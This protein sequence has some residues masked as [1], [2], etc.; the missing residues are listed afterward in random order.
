MIG[1]GLGSMVPMAAMALTGPVG[2]G[3]AAATGIAAGAGEATERAR[4][5]GASEEDIDTAGLSG[6]AIGAT[7]MLPIFRFLN[8]GG[9]E[10][11]Q[12]FADKVWRYV[13]SATEEGV[14]EAAAAMAQNMVEQQVYNPDADILNLDVAAEGGV[15]ATVGAIT[16]GLVD[17]AMRGKRRGLTAGEEPTPETEEERNARIQTRIGDKASRLG[18]DREDGQMDMFG[19]SDAMGPEAP[20]RAEEE[21]VDEE[22]T[23]EGLPI[24]DLF[25]ETL[26]Q[27]IDSPFR[28]PFGEFGERNIPADKQL[29]IVEDQT[30]P[31]ELL[32]PE[33]RRYKAAARQKQLEAKSA[34]DEKPKNE[35]EARKEETQAQL[36]EAVDTKKAQLEAI[37]GMQAQDQAQAA[38][39]VQAANMQMQG[40]SEPQMDLFPETR[41]A[42]PA[43]QPKAETPTRE[44][45]KPDPRQGDLLTGR[46]GQLPNVPATQFD[47]VEPQELL[48]PR[49][50]AAK[51][52]AQRKQQEAGPAARMAE[53]R[54][55]QQQQEAQQRSA[56]QA[57]AYRGQQ[58]TEQ[59]RA[60]Q[61]AQ[62]TGTPQPDMFGGVRGQVTPEPAAQ[63]ATTPR[64]ITKEMLD[65]ARILPAAPIR[66]RVTG[67][68]IN[69]PAVQ[70]DLRN[71]A[72]NKS[73][74]ATAKAGVNKLLQDAQQQGDLF[75]QPKRQPKPEVVQ[76]PVQEVKD[77]TAE[78]KPT[79]VRASS[80]DRGRSDEQRGRTPSA[81]P[82]GKPRAPERKRLAE[83]KPVPSKPARRAVRVDDTLEQKPAP[84]RITKPK[85]KKEEKPKAKYG[86]VASGVTNWKD[87]EPTK[88]RYVFRQAES[89]VPYDPRFDVK[90]KPK[91][92]KV[93]AEERVERADVSGTY[94]EQ[95]SQLRVLLAPKG[96]LD[97]NP[98][99]ENHEVTDNLPESD[100]AAIISVIKNT[101]DPGAK[102]TNEAWAARNYFV[103]S[104]HDRF[105][106]NL[107]LLGYDLANGTAKTKSVYNWVSKNLSPEA[108][109][110]VDKWT[111]RFDAE[112]K[113]AAH[114]VNRLDTVI[115][116]N[117]KAA[118]AAEQQLRK[119]TMGDM[120]EFR[121]SMQ[122]LRNIDAP[123]TTGLN[124]IE[125]IFGPLFRKELAK[126][127]PSAATLQTIHPD[128]SEALM[129]G[130][131]QRAL[132]LVGE[133]NPN[134][135]VQALA[136]KLA[137]MVGTTKV[138]MVDN[139]S[140]YLPEV[141]GDDILGY[142]YPRTNTIVIRSDA[143]STHT[144]L[145]EMMHAATKF[146]LVKQGHPV[147]RQLD[148]IFKEA[149]TAAQKLYGKENIEKDIYGL[150]DLDEFVAESM[151]DPEMQKFLSRIKSDGGKVNLWDRF[152]NA[153][154]NLVRNMLGYPSKPPF[155][156][157][158]ADVDHLVNTILAPAPRYINAN[159]NAYKS[160]DEIANDIGGMVAKE[161]NKTAG[162]RLKAVWEAVAGSARAIP[163][164]LLPTNALVDLVKDKIPAALQLDK[165]IHAQS[166]ELAKYASIN[167]ATIKKV[168]TWNNKHGTEHGKLLKAV[169]AESTVAEVDP[170]LTRKEAEAKYVLQGTTIPDQEK[171][172]VWSKLQE[173]WSRLKSVGGAEIYQTMRNSYKMYFDKI[174]ND[175]NVQLGETVTDPAML[176]QIREVVAKT[177]IIDPYFPLARTGRFWVKYTATDNNGQPDTY[178]EA[179]ESE[180]ERQAAI[181]ELKGLGAKDFETYVVDSNKDFKKA[182]P[183]SFMADLNK[184]LA[185]NKASKELKEAVTNLFLD[186][187]PAHSFM[188]SFK[189]RERVS[190]FDSDAI[191]VFEKRIH[192]LSHQAVA[193]KY[194]AQLQALQN[195]LEQSKREEFKDDLKTQEYID[196]LVDAADF[197][198]SPNIA[199]W[200]KRMTT[201]LFGMT[202]GANIS[203]AFVNMS[204]VPM[205]VGP[206]LSAE[207]GMVNTTKALNNAMR[208]FIGSGTNRK[209]D[210]MTGEGLKKVDAR[211]MPGMDNVDFAEM[212]KNPKTRKL[213]EDMEAFVEGMTEM[214]QLNRS[215]T[216]DILDFDNS[217]GLARK[218]NAVSGFLFHHAERFNRQVTLA[219]AYQLKLD[220]LRADK[221]NTMTEEQM[222]KVAL[223]DAV[224]RS[225]LYHGSV[226]AAAAPKLTRDNIGRVLALYKR[227]GLSQYYMMYNIAKNIKDPEARALGLKQAGYLLAGTS[228]V[229]GLHGMPLYGIFSMLYDM[230][231][232]DD[233]DDF[234]TMVRKA[235]G[236]LAFNGAGNALFG[237]DMASRMGLS[238]LLFRDPFMADEKTSVQILI[239]QLGGPAL[240]IANNIERGITKI[241][242]G[243]TVKG[244]EAI[245]PAAL[246]NVIKSVRYVSDEANITNSRGAVITDDLDAMELIGQFMGFAPARYAQQSAKNNNEMRKDKNVNAES[247]KLKRRAYMAIKVGDY[248]EYRN[249]IDEIRAFNRRNPTVAIDADSLNKSLKASDRTTREMI[250]GIS[251]SNRRRLEA[252]RSLDEFSD[253]V[254]VW[255]FL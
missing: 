141:K 61:M 70:Q 192:A 74:S 180:A 46:A 244:I 190:G 42:Q 177:H 1:E 179:F 91:R 200:S 186:S 73:V 222:R 40:R 166:G 15:G 31:E 226:H 212:K 126:I 201:G 207:Y 24:D 33:L 72:N 206:Q 143:A 120:D 124:D 50:R 138:V 51:L 224:V 125:D 127:D 106:D 84:K 97:V 219:A 68:D 27:D 130:E 217:L 3:A 17:L 67:K 215:I 105:I 110:I 153:V 5:A 156:S 204:Q 79:R 162:T 39:D 12:N 203:A 94:G 2:F 243:D 48:D 83:D 252:T 108:K 71:F 197:A 62:D 193:L 81:R 116:S 55:A 137:S 76:E 216:N 65:N 239:E 242:E 115:K 232:E 59:G 10:I 18:V 36:D 209:V 43:Q 174:L 221:N 6:A 144:L 227:Y 104:K 250:N 163:S 246:R 147:T 251:I 253:E 168:Q 87:R 47:T 118:T 152:V 240:G 241:Y 35:V 45:A 182:P 238:D 99:L 11:A 89:M 205:V 44:E 234:D 9:K 254:T 29:S 164:W 233:E 13:G 26:E 173:P 229:A 96:T 249:I 159:G 150:T 66:K 235:T 123:E 213:A 139:I 199:N 196:M 248:T 107:V 112:N 167:E 140:D 20:A 195:E 113:H 92:D 148:T 175:L 230:F 255:D 49:M 146:T 38:R 185:A 101:R 41:T 4:A 202:L 32:D 100:N 90:N 54:A 117:R 135:Q 19:L 228:V 178:Q 142:Y 88:P 169:I 181:E 225:D 231:N 154:A 133:T 165:L 77:G 8:R 111:K 157:A 69:D 52:A 131:L 21:L 171:L 28:T 191:G 161:Y 37:M 82:A 218:V 85:A 56:Q 132:L 63:T 183:A 129:R 176:K 194:G 236:E 151:T 58:A 16:Q 30:T 121:D 102:K 188:K 95:R 211:A 75:E 170:S 214:G 86:R 136:K 160:S 60:A 109:A 22:P 53:R 80:T 134:K 155:S 172:D 119:E 198:R 158:M 145:H 149:R 93:A 78:T 210:V 128:V 57:E 189:R 34:T 220:A 208:L 14:Q 23:P 64:V 247:S 122:D 245:S 7:E 223:E 25:P 98:A 114:Y 237:W 103:N 187:L 184:T